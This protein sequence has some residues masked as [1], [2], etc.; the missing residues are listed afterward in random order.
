MAPISRLPAV[1]T[2]I[3]LGQILRG[4]DE[5][6]KCGKAHLAL[7]WL[8]ERV[9]LLC[10]PETDRLKLLTAKISGELGCS[11]APSKGKANFTSHFASKLEAEPAFRG[12]PV[13]PSARRGSKHQISQ[14][15]KE[16][17]ALC[18]L[19]PSSGC[20][21]SLPKLLAQ[22]YDQAAHRR[23]GP[24]CG[25]E[26]N[27]VVI[28]DWDDTLFP[29]NFVISTVLPSLGGPG[30][31]LSADSEYY[32][33]LA[34]HAKQV[35]S[36]LRSA[37]RTAHVAIVTLS[38][39]PW[40]QMSADQF[41]PNLNMAK[42]LQELGITVYYASEHVQK[43][44]PETQLWEVMLDRSRGQLGMEVDVLEDGTLLVL[45]VL[46][47][48]QVAV[49]GEEDPTK[50]ISPGDRII[51]VNGAREELLA[52][53]RKLQL[54]LVVSR[55][56]VDMTPYEAAKQK[57]MSTCLAKLDHKALQTNAVSVGD[58]EVEHKALK[59]LL[60]NPSDDAVGRKSL[61]KTVSFLEHPSLE[62]LTQQ[63]K[64]LMV[65]LPRLIQHSG[66]FDLKMSKSATG[67][68]G[69]ADDLKHRLL[70]G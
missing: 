8:A 40:V 35:E 55:S 13:C 42:L 36:V 25:G 38:R 32:E 15:H 11:R 24:S 54:T 26:R 47:G 68:I 5:D 18:R 56:I 30:G 50:A 49:N 2:P 7:C 60:L 3:S 9:A 17:E 63:L 28:F 23:V 14:Q 51:E 48:G 66:H 61:C 37:R 19:S 69:P 67:S 41:L 70:T 64:V 31:T 12:Q 46:P 59:A 53:C 20:W 22:Q 33:R 10:V 4:G 6:P 45:A 1:A 21:A 34:S 29:T 16:K 44:A 65:W 27:S 39:S 62:T 57:D 43:R 58:S 52:E